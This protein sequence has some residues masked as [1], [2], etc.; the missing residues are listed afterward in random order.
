[1]REVFEYLLRLLKSRIFPL[2]MV[3]VILFAMLIYRIFN[4]QII[5]GSNYS[6]SLSQSIEK[7]MS[8]QATRGR[9]FDRNGKLLAYNDLAYSVKIADSGS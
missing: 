6:K 3:F 8:I 2:V 7:N 4:L 1:M 5:N 9:I